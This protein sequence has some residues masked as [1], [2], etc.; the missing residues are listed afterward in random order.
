VAVFGNSSV[1]PLGSFGRV[2]AVSV[3]NPSFDPM[4]PGFL[5][6]AQ[7][8]APLFNYTNDHS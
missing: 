6:S 7:Q 4:S 8:C 3:R 1:E 2:V 5:T